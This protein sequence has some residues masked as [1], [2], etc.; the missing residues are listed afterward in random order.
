[1]YICTRRIK[2]VVVVVVVVVKVQGASLK[3]VSAKSYG[4]SAR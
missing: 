3:G 2:V 1:M 4:S